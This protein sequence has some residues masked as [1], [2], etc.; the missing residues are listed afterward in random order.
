MSATAPTSC[1]RAASWASSAAPSCPK[2]TSS[3]WECTMSDAALAPTRPDGVRQLTRMLVRIPGVAVVLAALALVFG[4]AAPGFTSAANLSNVLVQST[5]LLLLALPM[6]LV[7]MTEGL[8]LSMGAVVT[9]A[10]I[11][12]ALVV[13]ATGSLGL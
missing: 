8:D 12:F 1:A 10:S 13:V 2:R 4:L 11:V 3:G 7:I 5:I 6:T 9:F